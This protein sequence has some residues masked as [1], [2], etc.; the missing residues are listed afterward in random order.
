MYTISPQNNNLK[1]QICLDNFVSEK[2]NKLKCYYSLIRSEQISEKFSFSGNKINNNIFINSVNSVIDNNR[3]LIKNNLDA[4]NQCN[5][6]YH[7]FSIKNGLGSCCYNDNFRGDFSY[8]GKIHHDL[9]TIRAIID[10]STDTPVNCITSP[11]FI[12]IDTHAPI[13]SSVTGDDWTNNVSKFVITAQDRKIKTPDSPEIFSDITKFH[14]GDYTITKSQDGKWDI[15]VDEEKTPEYVITEFTQD[16]DNYSVKITADKSINM[17]LPVTAVDECDN[18]SEQ[19][20]LNVKIDK[21]KPAV[22]GISADCTLKN[23]NNPDE[24]RGYKNTIV[25]TNDPGDDFITL[26]VNATDIFTDKELSSSIE[27]AFIGLSGNKTSSNFEAFIAD[28]SSDLAAGE[29]VFRIPKEEKAKS[30]FIKIEDAAG[31]FCRYDLSSLSDSHLSESDDNTYL[32]IDTTSPECSAK[33][34]CDEEKTHKA[35]I[36]TQNNEVQHWYTDYPEIRLDLNDKNPDI[37]SGLDSLAVSLNGQEILKTDGIGQTGISSYRLMVTD[38][39]TKDSE[40]KVTLFDGESEVCSAQTPKNESGALAFSVTLSDYASNLSSYDIPVFYVDNSSPVIDHSFTV[41]APENEITYTP[42]GTFTNEKVD[43][44][45]TVTD[46]MPSSGLDKVILRVGAKEY[47]TK[48]KP[49]KNDQG[50]YICR[51]SVP[52]NVID[53]DTVLSGNVSATAFDMAGNQTV[54]Y[55][56]SDTIE[57]TDW[58]PLMSAKESSNIMLENIKPVIQQKVNGENVVHYHDEILD[59][60]WYSGDVGVDYI[61]SDIQSGLRKIVLGVTNSFDAKTS[62]NSWDSTDVQEFEKNFTMSTDP[63]SDGLFTF[64][65]S[66]CDNSGNSE[67]SVLTVFKDTTAPEITGF[68]INQSIDMSLKRLTSDIAEYGTQTLTPEDMRDLMYRFFSQKVTQVTISAKD[69]NA[70]SGLRSIEYTL[71]DEAGSAV[72]HNTMPVDENGQITFMLDEGFKGNIAAC[73]SDNVHNTSE[74]ACM[75]G[76]VLENDARHMVSSDISVKLPDTPFTDSNG[77]PLYNNDIRAVMSVGD[78][79]SGIES[80]MWSITENG[81]DTWNETYIGSDSVHQKSDG[82]NGWE[83]KDCHKNLVSSA[84]SSADISKNAND[85]AL[86]LRIIDNCGN[87]S[88][89]AVP[90]S[91]DRTAPQIN[92]SFSSEAPDK[93]YKNIYNKARKATI[94]IRDRNFDASGTSVDISNTSSAQKATVSDFRLVSGTQGTDSAVYEAEVVFD[95]DG[96]YKLSIVSK[97]RCD[98][99]SEKYESDVFIIDTTAPVIS[100]KF[101]DEQDKK[102]YAAKRTAEITVTEDNF[103]ASRILI[104]GTYNSKNEN[105]P[106]LSEWKTTGNVHK[107]QIVFEEDGNYVFNVTGT[108]MASNNAQKSFNCEFC[109][110]KKVPEIKFDGVKD[111][112]SNRGQVIPVITFDD[113]NLDMSTVKVTINGSMNPGTRDLDGELKKTQTG[114]VFTGTDFAR[115]EKNDDI[116]TVTAQAKDWSGNTLTNSITFSVNRFGSTYRLADATKELLGQYVNTEQDVVLYEVNTDELSE[117]TVK[118]TKDGTTSTLTENEDYT[119]THTGG[120]G[121]WSEY[122][123][124]I[125]A[126]NFTDDASYSVTVSSCDKAG[127]QNV[128]SSDHSRLDINFGVDKTNPLCSTLDLHENESYK[129]ESRVFNLAISDNIGVKSVEVYSNENPVESIY[130]EEICTFSLSSSPEVQKITILVTDLAGNTKQM[131]IDNILISTSSVRILLHETWFKAASAAAALIAAAGAFLIIRKKRAR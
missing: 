63:G 50:Q 126:K 110:D 91:I 128:N 23:I 40:Y 11:I 117:N 93:A 70:S 129:A 52:E 113:I 46:K 115:E 94:S 122:E 43:I 13:I 39:G 49:Q 97:D 80:V 76:A 31:N 44:Y 86:K 104:S 131:I 26:R 48:D 111:K 109:I 58:V 78:E 101:N 37:C 38:A 75:S 9:I 61:Y 8:D 64:T 59:Q 16:N 82:V 21:D 81:I 27:N 30:A 68:S 71:Y 42:F 41:A 89:D 116:Y 17:T 19:S 66:A 120:N 53:K 18:V 29:L 96:T 92:V 114:A 35:D 3:I 123:Y 47:V 84:E 25:C 67:N 7:D 45:V 106:K 28:D 100:V 90:F 6:I 57:K 127:N 108:D 32:I 118:I 83:I 88:E 22:N 1:Y 85:L 102:Y 5:V 95:K 69:E 10:N 56:V 107:A 73:A 51:F 4:N 79:F 24:S 98:N 112:S 12:Y 74:A 54:W 15:A 130:E 103:D 20:S 62:E 105:F 60:D 2:V 34:C 124:V 121:K 99:T 72:S 125:S 119:V 65:T 77:L 87:V 36:I 14:I 33:I 55:D